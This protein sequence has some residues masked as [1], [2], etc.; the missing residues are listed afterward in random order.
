[1][2]GVCGFS[3]HPMT[4]DHQITRSLSFSVPPRLCGESL[5]QTDRCVLQ[6][7]GDPAGGFRVNAVV[8]ERLRYDAD[9]TLDAVE[10]VELAGQPQRAQGF[11]APSRRRRLLRVLV[12]DVSV[13]E[14][15]GFALMAVAAEL[16][17]AAIIGVAHFGYSPVHHHVWLLSALHKVKP[18]WPFTN[19]SNFPNL[20][21]LPLP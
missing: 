5:P 20:S 19:L 8:D 13:L 9:R 16:L 14:R 2:T 1:M 18:F 15:R 3:D 21:P 4:R 7:D 6:L 11:L 12:A 10:V 17:A